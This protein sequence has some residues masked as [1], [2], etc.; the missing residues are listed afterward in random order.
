MGHYD[1]EVGILKC[2]ESAG[3]E[4]DLQRVYKSIPDF[5]Q[6]TEEHLKEKYNQPAY[7]HQVRSHI[8]NLCRSGDLIQKNRG[9][10]ALTQKGLARARML[11]I[12]IEFI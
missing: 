12:D 9:R 1:W 4:A 10:Y 3:K 6:L 7:H 5:I 2:F 8:W 11:P